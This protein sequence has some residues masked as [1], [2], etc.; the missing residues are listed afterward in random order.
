[1]PRSDAENSRTRCVKLLGAAE[2]PK[3]IM[4]IFKFGGWLFGIARTMLLPGE[5]VDSEVE[6]AALGVVGLEV[7]L[8]CRGQREAVI[9]LQRR[10]AQSKLLVCEVVIVLRTRNLAWTALRE[11]HPHFRARI[12]DPRRWKNWRIT[13]A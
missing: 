9:I 8:L 4:D 2:L 5:C 10:G 1:M 7:E 13:T 12:R 6:E 11:D 3:L